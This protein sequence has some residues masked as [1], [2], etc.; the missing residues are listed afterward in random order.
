[1]IEAICAELAEQ[2][3]DLEAQVAHRDKRLL[4]AWEAIGGQREGMSLAEAIAADQAAAWKALG[5]D[6]TGGSLAEAIETAIN[7]YDD[8]HGAAVDALRAYLVAQGHSANPV[9]MPGPLGVLC[10]VLL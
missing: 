6:D 10:D 3:I 4:E 5:T 8:T 2:V 9:T 1:M 7:A